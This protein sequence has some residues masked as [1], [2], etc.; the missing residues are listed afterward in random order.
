IRMQYWLYL[1]SGVGGG[2]CIHPELNLWNGMLVQLRDLMRQAQDYTALFSRWNKADSRIGLLYSKY[3]LAGGVN[4]PYESTLRKICGDLAARDVYPDIITEEEI[5]SGAV[6]KYDALIVAGVDYQPRDV[7][8]SLSDYAKSKRLF[9][10]RPDVIKIAGAL[11]LDADK[12]VAGITPDAVTPSADIMACLLTAGGMDY[13]VAYNHSP[14]GRTEEIRFRNRAGVSAVCDLYGRRKL[15]MRTEGKD[16]LVKVPLTAYNGAIL[17]LLPDDIRSVRLDISGK[18]TRGEIIKVVASL[19][20]KGAV[21]GVVPAMI[22]VYD[23]AG[24]KTQYGGK[25]IF[26]DGRCSF[27]MPLAVNE[28]TGAWRITVRE[29]VSGQEATAVVSIK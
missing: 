22:E 28:L 18:A 29:M 8:E 11:K 15:D 1:M 19:G 17:A 25:S 21:K 5:R 20:S 3:H 9:V 24:G 2:F 4:E 10:D 13:A 16:L 27:D 12:A 6:A 7:I 14:A 26:R 23:P